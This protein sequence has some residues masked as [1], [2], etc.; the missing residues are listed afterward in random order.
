MSTPTNS[1]YSPGGS[2]T[3]LTNYSSYESDMST[4]HRRR[5]TGQ[6]DQTARN[7]YD[8]IKEDVDGNHTIVPLFDFISIALG[9]DLNRAKAIAG[10]PWTLSVTHLDKYRQAARE[11]SM[12]EPFRQM[13]ISLLADVKNAFEGKSNELWPETDD[14]Y[15]W[16]AR[17]E[18]I[19]RTAHTKRK[20]DMIVLRQKPLPGIEPV[21][22]AGRQIFEFKRKSRRENAAEART[23][24]YSPIATSSTHKSSDTAP[25]Q[26]LYATSSLSSSASTQMYTSSSAIAN[27][28][29]AIPTTVDFEES[30]TWKNPASSRAADL[31]RKNRQNH[32]I[33]QPKRS[34]TTSRAAGSSE[35]IHIITDDTAQLAGYALESLDA[36]TR[37][38]VCGIF[39]DRFKVSL[40]YYDRAC[41]IRSEF[42]DFELEPG[43]LAAVLYAIFTCD[44]KHA[45]FDPY[46]SFPPSLPRIP[47]HQQDI[48]GGEISLP[49]PNGHA[50][51]RFRIKNVLFAYRGLIGRGTMVYQVTPVV[52]GVDTEDQALKISWP[53][54]NR[55]LEADTIKILRE[56]IPQWKDHLPD[57][58]SSVTLT[59]EELELPRV[60]LLKQCSIEKFEDR[61]LHMMV[62][63]LYN[64]LWEVGSIEKFQI[65]FVDCVE[66]H[67]HAYMAGRI[68][69]RDV[70][71]NNLMFKDAQDGTV[72]GVV[73][74]WDMAGHVGSDDEV[75][76]STS[77]HRT[78]TI[79]FMARDLLVDENETPPPHLYR[80]D[81]ESFFYILV[82][83]AFHYDFT[84]KERDVAIHPKIRPWDAPELSYARTAKVALFAAVKEKIAL[85]S[86][87][88]ARSNPLLPWISSLW[89]VFHD[90]TTCENSKSHLPGWDTKTLGGVVTFSTVMKALGRQP[91]VNGGS[92][93]IDRF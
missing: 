69:H 67:Y 90:G 37:H 14:M 73:N 18:G 33:P 6:K 31:K 21:W 82:W 92:T 26:L 85:F 13:A 45:G 93:A 74:D 79:P 12:Y 91:R 30:T 50:G 23:S 39:I 27:T 35:Q 64:N 9:L 66:C 81:L 10:K 40:W 55:C 53:S 89:T 48:I 32:D 36:S 80:H 83:A 34:R 3:S 7:I 49:L 70:S 60:Q 86:N 4:P 68:L 42:F 76:L 54:R 24:Q 65:V 59:A 44:D 43:K 20:P 17:G 71:E 52:D 25:R 77:K 11:P 38:F 15:F 84:N 72:K 5:V 29:P 87:I 51:P 63:T 78:G 19:L 28:D 62:M 22:C 61:Y 2:A 1:S 41:I 8:K 75:P 47:Q 88:P 58:S 16:H 56:K 57:V 46:M